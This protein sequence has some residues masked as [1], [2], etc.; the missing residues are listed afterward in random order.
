MRINTEKMEKV[1]F[2]GKEIAFG[3]CRKNE[4]GE[5]VIKVYLNR[6]YNEDLTIYEN[7]KA[8]AE[9]TRDAIIETSRLAVEAGR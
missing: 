1:T 6:I 5:W 7:S 3:K 9:A 8:D 4:F 2:N